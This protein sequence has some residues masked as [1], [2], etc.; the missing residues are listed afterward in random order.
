MEVKAMA[1]RSKA[2][3]MLRSS[4]TLLQYLRPS[5]RVVL[6]LVYYSGTKQL[7]ASPCLRS[8]AFPYLLLKPLLSPLSCPFTAGSLF[9]ACPPCLPSAACEIKVELHPIGEYVGKDLRVCI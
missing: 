9:G 6:C 1:L 7:H 8:E 3:G 4:K 2:E 5:G